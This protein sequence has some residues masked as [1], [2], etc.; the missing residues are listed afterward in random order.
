VPRWIGRT[1]L[2]L[3]GLTVIAG[4]SPFEYMAGPVAFLMLLPISLGLALGDKQHA[5]GGR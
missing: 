3:G 4:V 5:A 1:G 2:V